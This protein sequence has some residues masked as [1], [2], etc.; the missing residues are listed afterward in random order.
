MSVRRLFSRVRRVARR[1]GDPFSFFERFP[2]IFVIR[3]LNDIFGRRGEVF[4][5]FPEDIAPFFGGFKNYMSSI[6][7]Q[8]W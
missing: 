7:K 3:N 5:R 2:C 8:P 4:W 1:A 6:S